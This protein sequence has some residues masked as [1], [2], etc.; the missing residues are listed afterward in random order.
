MLLETPV[1]AGQ[2]QLGTVAA[3]RLKQ[4]QMAGWNNYSWRDG[5]TTDSGLSWLIGI[6][7]GNRFMTVS[8]SRFE[9]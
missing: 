2:L 4:S 3:S 1:V 8:N 5:I 7:D 6:V 9:Q